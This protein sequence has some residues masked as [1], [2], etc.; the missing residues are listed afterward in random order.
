MNLYYEDAPASEHDDPQLPPLLDAEKIA[1]GTDVMA[2]AIGRAAAG[3]TGLVCYSEATHCLDMAITLAP[4]VS[5]SKAMQM[6][7]TLMTALGDSI[8]AL[9]PPEVG[10]RY[11]FPGAILFNRGHAGVV[12]VA[13]A[14]CQDPSAD[15]PDWL[16][17]SAQLRLTFDRDDHSHEY[18]M[19]NTSLEEEG[20]GFISRT[21]LV[22]SVSRHFLVWLHKWEEEGF[23]PI[24]E[25]WLKRVDD[26]KAL[27]LKDGRVANFLGLDEEGGALVTV[28]DRPETITLHNSAGYFNHAP[29]DEL[30]SGSGR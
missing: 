10:V 16:V 2:K 12:R 11:R 21:R 7:Y 28:D 15:I 23:R 3:E 13:A 22:E 8:G 18:R 19:A 27:T 20:G 4:E 25:T 14:P 24:H 30:P 9:A 6:H 5:L 29:L 26:D 1:K 17:V